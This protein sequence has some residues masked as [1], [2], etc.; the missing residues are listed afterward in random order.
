MK[1]QKQ[2]YRSIRYQTK[3]ERRY[4]TRA[5]NCNSK[6]INSLELIPYQQIYYIGK[7]REKERKKKGT[8]TQNRNTAKTNIVFEMRSPRSLTF[9]L[10]IPM[11]RVQFGIQ[12]SSLEST[13]SANEHQEANN[14]YVDE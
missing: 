1:S 2:K 5:K 9:F 6:Q 14:E 10:P 12:N 7:E 8:K 3:D 4:Q 13:K 11:K